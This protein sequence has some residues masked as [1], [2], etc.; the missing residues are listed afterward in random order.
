MP[1]NVFSFTL[2][3]GACYGHG[4]VLDDAVHLVAGFE[5]E[6]RKDKECK[7]TLC[8][9]IDFS[10]FHVWLKA[11]FQGSHRDLY[12]PEASGAGRRK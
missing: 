3:R 11:E 5:H 6:P 7:F 8:E 9:L 10:H 1:G 2:L 12:W 4:K